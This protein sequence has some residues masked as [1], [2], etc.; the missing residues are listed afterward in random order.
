MGLHN[1]QHFPVQGLLPKEETQAASFVRKNPEFDGRGTVI[2]ILDTGVDPG[3]PGLQ[4]TTEGLPKVID[5]IDCTG[6]GDVQ[7]TTV[8][9]ACSIEE[10]GRTRRILQGLSGRT[11]TIGDWHNPTGKYRLG[12]K[13]SSELFPK[14]L[15]DRLQKDRRKK[16]QIEHHSL[17]TKT[18]RELD[19]LEN[20]QEPGDK[21]EHERRKTD[22]KT[23]LEVLK[24]QWKNYED[25]GFII[26][27]VVF[28]DGRKWRAVVDMDESGDL[29]NAPLLTTYSDERQ[30]VR[31]SDDSMLNFSVNIYDEGETLSIVTLAGSHGTH[32]AAISA[33]H[34][35]EDR[36]LDGVAPGAQIVSLKI[37]DT[38][39][40][41]M[42]T[43]TGLIRAAIE[44]TR[45]KV[46]LANISYGEA[47]SIPD[48]G[49]FVELLRDEVINKSGCIVVSSAGNAGPAL[50][51][52]GAPGGTTSGVIGVGAYVTQG[53]MQA[54]YAMLDTV[55]E[56]SYTWSSRGPTA[57]GA[58]VDIYA[59]GAAVT[60]VPQYTTQH[61]QLMNGTSMSSPNCCGCIALLLSALKANK[62]PY[63]PY[64]VKAAIERSGSDIGDEFGIKFIQVERAWDHLLETGAAFTPFD[65]EYNI[66]VQ[67]KRNARGIYLRDLDETSDVQQFQ[68]E[69]RP[70]F[71]KEN[72]PEVN[73]KKLDLEVRAG[74]ASTKRWLSAPEYVL[75]NNG[76]RS[77]SVRVDPTTLEPGFHFA[78]VQ[79]YDTQNPKAGPIF[80]IPVTV[81]KPEVA[82]NFGAEER[83]AYFRWEGLKF[84][85]G[86]IVRRFVSVPL[87][88]NFAELIVRSTDRASPARFIV[89]TMQLQE[90]TRYTKFE[91]SY[92]FSLSRTGSN[93]STSDAEQS[94]YTKLFP[95]LSYAT[96]EVCLAQFWSSLE[97]SRVDVELKFHGIFASVSTGNQGGLG[98]TTGSGGDLVMLNSGNNGFTRVDLWTGVRKEEISLSVT[99]DTLRR[100]IRPNDAIISPLKSR[101][102]LP[103]TRQLHQLVLTYIVK[104][105]ETGGGVNI[106][107]RVPKANEVLYDAF[108]ESFVLIVFDANKKELSY[109]DIYPKTLKVTDGTY[110]I[111]VQVIS[112]SVEFLDSLTSMPLILDQALGK[113]GSLNAYKGLGYA[114]RE[115][116]TGT[117][118]KR[119]LQRGERAVAWLS[120]EIPTPKDAK[121]GDLLV[122]NMSAIG[123]GRKLDGGALYKVAWLVPPSPREKD[124]KED[125]SKDEEKDDATL[126]REATR[127]LE[128]SWI[129]KMKDDCEREKLISKLETDWPNHLPLLVTRLEMIGEEAEKEEKQ[130]EKEGGNVSDGTVSSVEELADKIVELADEK[131][132]A[133]W[134]GVRRDSNRIYGTEK[135]RKDRLRKGKEMDKRK[136]PIVL[137]YTYKCWC[138]KQAILKSPTAS[139]DTLARLLEVLYGWLP[140]PPTSSSTQYLLLWSWYQRRRGLYGEVAKVT[141]K[142]LKDGSKVGDARWGDVAKERDEAFKALE[143]CVWMGYE[144]RWSVVKK[145][146]NW[147]A[148]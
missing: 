109:Q 128:I 102:V 71:F 92:S 123:G 14:L 70:H 98:A 146:A 41:S 74:L 59:P 39:L 34:Y 116:K 124:K 19:H 61:S 130:Q 117:F 103:D 105:S 35:P 80:S 56:G 17:V 100:F 12:L 106:T 36:N 53:M 22:T 32:V 77:F 26:D 93:S 127:D 33:A 136:E 78:E 115:D 58:L 16:F 140:D 126:L 49:R 95:V 139:L 4:V 142:F 148:F 42:E 83:V 30:F 112:G 2:A 90:Q 7:C 97:S 89:H 141:N 20:L 40:G 121:Q 110:T 50:T 84:E 62:I 129:K 69:V 75:L 15:V 38:R 85:P 118:K 47:A 87:G 55:K 18:E 65:V 64:R 88:A 31:F 1:I 99:L 91:H 79:G 51:T 143:W 46:D 9:E 76:G 86:T 107:P 122:G 6:S 138:N 82:G 13:R 119:T 21:E 67:D 5:I 131:E 24:E 29:R 63:T 11:L 72:D 94:V 25:P 145:P 135:E 147:S 8:V 101:D 137:A 132:V 125:T 104:I 113:S 96:L 68:V 144:A 44:L 120:G 134:F 114:V 66:S 3:A 28:H 73:V 52:T 45:L 54:E 81:C 43:G 48:T 37:G 57:D 27:C 111:R 10:D 133:M 23:R 108:F 60:S